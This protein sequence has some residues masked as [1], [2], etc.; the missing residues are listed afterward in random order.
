MFRN[1]FNKD[2][3]FKKINSTSSSMDTIPGSSNS[4]SKESINKKNIYLQVPQRRRTQSESLSEDSETRIVKVRRALS[5]DNIVENISDMSDSQLIEVPLINDGKLNEY[6]VEDAN[7]K[8]VI[9]RTEVNGKVDN[10]LE[11]TSGVENFSELQIINDV[12]CKTCSKQRTSWK[13][14]DILSGKLNNKNIYFSCS[15]MW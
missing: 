2:K 6:T 4:S 5:Q 8:S 12:S 13:C 14:W 9:D 15:L 10:I 3:S 1:M 11:D 7:L